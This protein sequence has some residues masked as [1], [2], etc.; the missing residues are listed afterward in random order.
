MLAFFALPFISIGGGIV[1]AA[2]TIF[3]FIVYPF[4][5]TEKFPVKVNDVMKDMSGPMYIWQNI[6]S[7]IKYL[8]V[9]FFVFVTKYAFEDLNIFYALGGAM[10]ALMT[11]FF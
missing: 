8:I 5:E 3:F 6:I 11:Y 9:L 1:Q 4:M 10:L 2:M 7:R